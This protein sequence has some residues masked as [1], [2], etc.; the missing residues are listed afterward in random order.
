[1]EAVGDKRGIVPP[2]EAE[3]FRR[4]RVAEQWER[5]DTICIGPGARDRDDGWFN[6]WADFAAADQLEWFAGRS[7]NVGRS[8]TNQTSERTDFAQDFYQTNI[9]WIAP[10]GLGQFQQNQN[11]AQIIPLLFLHDLPNQ[12]AFSMIMADADEIAVAP[13]SHFPA[14][15]GVTDSFMAGLA[16]P[17][18][19]AGNQGDTHVS[20]S[21]KWPEPIMLAAKSRQVMRARIDQP[22]RNLLASIPGPDNLLVPAGE[23]NVPYP[24][25]YKIRITHRGPRYLQ[26]RG[27]RSSA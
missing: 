17:A 25:W 3:Q 7:T 27:A 1:M 20:N 24:N 15:F 5:Y 8:Y 18:T 14:A 26:L 22:V 2:A 11:D 19:L 10:I 9:E 4:A 6:T 23:A 21:W 16:S 12:M 13:G